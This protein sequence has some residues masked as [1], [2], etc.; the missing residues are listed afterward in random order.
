MMTEKLNQRYPVRYE[1]VKHRESLNA[2]LLWVLGEDD[3]SRKI[4]ER[5]GYYPDSQCLDFITNACDRDLEALKTIRG[6]VGRIAIFEFPLTISLLNT[7]YN[8]I[9]IGGFGFRPFSCIIGSNISL[10]L[11]YLNIRIYPPIS[12]N[13]AQSFPEITKTEVADEYHIITIG[14]DYS[15]TGAYTKKQA[16]HKVAS[17]LFILDNILQEQ[18][19]P[20]L[21]PIPLVVGYYQTIKNNVGENPYFI[22]WRVPYQ[23]KR[24]G[25]LILYKDQS[26][27]TFASFL[28]NAINAAPRIAKIL[29]NFLHDK[30]G[31]THNQVVAGNYFVPKN[32]DC[33]PYLADYTT[34]HPLYLNTQEVARTLELTKLIG[35]LL[36]TIGALIPEHRRSK[37]SESLPLL[38]FLYFITLESYLGFTPIYKPDNLSED[39]Y[40][41]LSK[42][43]FLEMS[44]AKSLG[45]FPNQ[46]P[47]V[48]SWL[49]IQQIEKDLLNRLSQTK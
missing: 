25:A 36:I 44:R 46:L 35:N 4:A 43:I 8:T 10:S 30:L 31:L 1:I 6:A 42:A 16:A 24:T 48:S 13:F 15:F 38:V 40:D 39:L 14:D 23:G 7:A 47:F 9:E 32:E 12:E 28:K 2:G 34:V 20:F 26:E 21:L 45:F 5:L 37:I 29:K 19:T 41:N 3:F 11:D 33:L 27:L 49:S 17:T 18:S 22:A